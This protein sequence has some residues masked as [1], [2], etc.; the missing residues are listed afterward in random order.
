MVEENII[1]FC[2]DEIYYY[3]YFHYLLGICSLSELDSRYSI[4]VKSA[5][6][7]VELYSTCSSASC[8]L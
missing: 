1:E 2:Y 5:S 6:L 8:I 4:S 3:Y 7:P